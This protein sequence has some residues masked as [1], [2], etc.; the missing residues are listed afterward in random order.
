MTDAPTFREGLGVIGRGIRDEPRTFTVA[1]VG[2][3]LFGAALAGSG[4]VLGRVTDA[5]LVPA[6]DAGTVSAR[7]AWLAFGAMALVG[8]LTALGVIVR[9][10]YATVTQ[11]R[12][13]ARYRRRVSRQYLRLPLAWHRRHPTG[14]LLSNANADVEAA[15]TVFAPLPFSFGVAVMLV[16]AGITMF[17]EDVVLGAVAFTVLP[18][19][20][21][22]NGLYQKVMSPRVSRAQQLRADV[23]DVA[24]ESF[25]GALVVKTLGRERE[26]TDRFGR[27]AQELREANVAVGRA[28]AAFE[29][30]V[31]ALPTLGTLV[32]LAV[33]T[34]RVASGAV[35]AGVVVQ[36]AYQLTLLAF[37]VRAIGWVLAELPR[38]VVGWRRVDAVLR[39]EGR[40]RHGAERLPVT[41]LG[42]AVSAEGVVHDV[43]D[44]D[45]SRQR[46][47]HGVD[48]VAP[49]GSTVAVVGST[50]SGKSTLASVLVRLVD[51]A[52][53]RVRLDGL[54]VR[55]VVAGGEPG[56]LPS[57]V[58]YVPQ[59]TFVFDDTVRGNITLGL[60][61]VPDE[62][63]WHA[64]RA[65]RA[66]G[67]VSALPEGLDTRVGERG[68]SLSGGQRQRLAIARALV[69]RPSVLVLDDATSAVDPTVEQQ[70]L[71]ALR[72]SDGVTV[73]VVAYRRSTIALADT[74]VHLEHGRV[75]DHG[76]HEELMSRD[77]GY[78]TLVEAYAR[79]AAE[80]EQLAG[81]GSGA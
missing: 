30:V 50:G 81:R 18:L 4:W 41:R 12:L 44:P 67:F 27:R 16:V 33:G 36:V 7:D 78:R 70:I 49:R 20:A 39:A 10:G 76:S 69:R 64:L 6:F 32:V 13:Q 3:A 17:G 71:G 55:D 58:A 79:D 56:S 23:S 48:L 40:M 46:L 28:R 80:R 68:A 63:V 31:E 77:T 25:D 59:G 60:D 26:E 22:S 51:P 14:Q 45:G 37:P 61:D 57:T 35:D 2:S 74:V 8:L 66:D 54:D 72:G 21:V 34:L 52:E 42:R 24:H 1:V 53:G 29:P 73:L 15:W 65:A 5:V 38:S 43:V 47:L 19:L 9:R 75:V 11:Y 62:Q